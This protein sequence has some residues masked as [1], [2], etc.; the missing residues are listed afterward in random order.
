MWTMPPT[1]RAYRKEVEAMLETLKQEVLEANLLLPKYG[2]VT[3]TWGN[4]S[5]I[6]MAYPSLPSKTRRAGSFSFMPIPKWWVSIRGFPA[7]QQGQ[8]SSMW[9]PR[10]Y[11]FHEEIDA[12]METYK[13]SYDIATDK[14][15]HIRYQAREEIAMKKML[16]EQ[17]CKAF[18]SRL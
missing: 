10:E 2:L 13:A 17:G 1:G 11:S 16:D 5:A 8:T 7:A 18:S 4:V 14:I 3:F 12:L 15:D 6:D 9:A